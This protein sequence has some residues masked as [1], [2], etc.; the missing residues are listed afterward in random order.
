MG[1]DISF[2]TYTKQNYSHYKGFYDKVYPMRRT[3]SFLQY[4]TS[5]VTLHLNDTKMTVVY[6]SYN[7][8][9]T[10]QGDNGRFN[11]DINKRRYQYIEKEANLYIFRPNTGKE[12]DTSTRE[13]IEIYF[14]AFSELQQEKMDK[15][16]TWIAKYTGLDIY[17]MQTQQKP[18]CSWIPRWLPLIGTKSCTRLV[19]I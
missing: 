5:S 15:F 13:G 11:G 3:V 16:I 19:L 7:D 9:K 10:T 6:D 14:G 17:E 12:E 8:M 2:Y 4:A 1:N 18:R